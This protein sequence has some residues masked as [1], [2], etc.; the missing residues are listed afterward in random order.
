MR[1][2]HIVGLICLLPVGGLSTSGQDAV[3]LT[4][5]CICPNCH[6]SYRAGVKDDPTA[7]LGRIPKSHQVTPRDI[8]A[9]PGLGG[10]IHTDTQRSGRELEWYGVIG[11][12]TAVKI[13]ADGDIHLQL[14]NVGP[15]G[16]DVQLIAEI[17]LGRRW[18]PI[19]REVLSW[20]SSTLPLSVTTGASLALTQHPV[21]RITGRAFYDGEHAVGGD[22]RGNRRVAVGGVAASI[23]E[24]HPVAQLRRVRP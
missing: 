6:G 17:P 22:T 2:L 18:C 12:V 16:A 10:E 21:V 7:P 19:R 14:E 8:A 1:Y 3:I 13:E 24:I 23:W 4:S 9:W 5:A 20:S 11:R 15:H